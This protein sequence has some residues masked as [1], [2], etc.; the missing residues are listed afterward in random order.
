MRTTV[1]LSWSHSAEELQSLPHIVYCRAS[2]H[3][4]EPIS[5]SP[6]RSSRMRFVELVTEAIVSDAYSRVRALKVDGLAGRQGI[7]VVA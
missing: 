5:P 3:H 4:G 1:A 6:S 7:A 2:T